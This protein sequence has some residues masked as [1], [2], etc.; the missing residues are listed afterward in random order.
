MSENK[1]V[2][3][4]YTDTAKYSVKDIANF[5]RAK[6]IDPSP[7]INDF[8]SEFESKVGIFPLSCPISFQLS[9]IGVFE[10][11][12]CNAKNGYRIL[13]TVDSETDVVVHII[14]NQRQ[15]IQA[16]LLKRMIEYR[17]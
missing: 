5:L 4:K 11:R 6:D 12:E 13:Y 14:L 1:T 8:I 16:L 3:I 9:K 7:I 2:T 10:Y 15:D 17:I